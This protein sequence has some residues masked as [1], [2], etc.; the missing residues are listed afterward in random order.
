METMTISAKGWL[1][2]PADLRKKY[3]LKPGSRVRFVDYGGVLSI[4]PAQKDG[5]V[6]PTRPLWLLTTPR[7]IGVDPAAAQMKL[8]SGPERIE[9]GW[10]DGDD[11]GRDYFVGSDARGEELW[12]YRDRKGEWFIHGVFA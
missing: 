8:K 11:V 1:V 4:V 10:W 9:T 2:I 6:W 12:I 5:S 3:D 7:S